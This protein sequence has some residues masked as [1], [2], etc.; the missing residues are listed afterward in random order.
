MEQVSE[1]DG[2]ALDFH[3]EYGWSQATKFLLA[4]IF[5]ASA[6]KLQLRQYQNIICCDNAK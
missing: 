2:H 6:I 1:S 3:R 5:L 4:K